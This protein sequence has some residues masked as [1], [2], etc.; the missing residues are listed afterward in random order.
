MGS[1]FQYD[2]KVEV[3]GQVILSIT[4]A[5]GDMVNPILKEHQLSDVKE[6]NW[7]PLKQWLDVLDVISGGGF[8]LDAVAAGTKI[9]ETAVF[10][11]TIDSVSSAIHSIDVA[12]HM[13][14]RNGE[15]G[16]YLTEDI[17][18]QEIKVVA[19]TPYPDYFNYGILY[20]LAKAFLEKGQSLTVRHDDTV[21][22]KKNGGTSRTYY[23]KWG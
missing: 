22:N 19:E 1:S 8:S 13:N 10:P 21:A 17:S 23:V 14:H 15:I 18:D 7:Y 6:D 12:Y 11:P 4:A 3:I 20:G 16:H 5:L 2:P 9:S